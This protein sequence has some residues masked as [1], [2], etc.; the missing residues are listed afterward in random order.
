[1]KCD[2][3]VHSFYSGM[4]TTPV[5]NRLSRESYSDPQ[6]VYAGLK[7]KGMDL[8]TLT[9]HDSIG[10]AEPLRHYADFF[11][12]EEVTCRMPSGTLAHIGVFDVTERQHF[13][14]QRR[15]DDL[16]SLLV[17]LTERRLLF[18]VNH[19]F[20]ALTGRR[21][22]EDFAWFAA[23]FPAMETRN[24]QML[25]FLNRQAERLARRLRKAALGGSDAHALRSIGSAYTEVPSA[26]NKAEFFEGIRAGK[27]LVR[28]QNGGYLKLTRDVLSIYARMVW[29]HPWKFLLTPAAVLVPLVTSATLVR[30]FSFARRWG[31]RVEKCDSAFSPDLADLRRGN[32][33]EVFAWP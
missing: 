21:E 14:I 16:I 23:Y 31:A 25:P 1:M 10:G 17:Y 32:L 13:E 20:S 3:H 26:R 19:V 8:V 7:R 33:A 4:Y 24:G 22:L 11:V 5:L 15:R 27:A 9:D 2:L 12:S 6:Q 18:T 30:E 28:G 29:E